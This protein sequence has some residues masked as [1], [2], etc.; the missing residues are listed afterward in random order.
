MKLLKVVYRFIKKIIF[1]FLDRRIIRLLSKES[2]NLNDN[3]FI[4]G[5]PIHGNI[6]DHAILIAEKQFLREEIGLVN[7]H[8]IES[9]FFLRNTKKIK[10][11]I[12]N[13]PIFVTGGG[14]LGSL[15]IGEERMFRTVLTSFKENTI[16]VFP[17][18]IYFSDDEYG[19]EQLEISKKVYAQHPNLSICCREKFS[20]EFMKKEFPECNIYL[21][22]DMV[23]YLNTVNFKEKRNNQV[24]FCIR[25]DK[26]K[27]N[28][29]LNKFEED[30]SQ[31]NMK[32]DYTDTVISKKIFSR[33]RE[34]IFINKIKEF[35]R[36][37]IVVTDRL[38]G[39]IFALL[40]KTPC[41]VLENKSYKIKGVYE[42]IKN[43]K[44]IK[45]SNEENFSHDLEKMF[46]TST[47]YDN[48]KLNAN[49][50]EFAVM[51]REILSKGGHSNE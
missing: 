46:E 15:W 34:E 49:F 24:L 48:K 50:K 1:Y 2:K 11:I 23:L 4:I 17:Q 40:S 44:Y 39:M 6:G 16:I 21:F 32:I 30:F 45:L 22:P 33:E 31:K 10:K 3:V 28:Y 12:G 9:N 25:K 29:N 14:F 18:T 5:I 51:L 8:E 19:A 27:I 13:S 36:Y 43:V 38:H 7:I 47:V 26:E 35:S 42:W 20:F 37:K 41:I